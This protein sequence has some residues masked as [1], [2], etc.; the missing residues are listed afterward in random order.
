MKFQDKVFDKILLSFV[1]HEVEENLAEKILVEA[2][3]V[4]NL[5]KSED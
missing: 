1:L 4:L 2:K 5:K 3:R